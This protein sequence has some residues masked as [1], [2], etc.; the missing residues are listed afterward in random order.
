MLSVL[1]SLPRP[2]RVTA[3]VAAT[4]AAIGLTTVA[5]VTAATTPLASLPDTVPSAVA[6]ADRTGALPDPQ[7]LSIAIELELRDEDQP[8]AFDSG[9]STPGSPTY[10]QYLSAAQFASRFSPSQAVVDTVRTVLTVAGLSVG[11]VSGNRQVIDAS[12]RVAVLDALFHTSLSTYQVGTKEFFA[13]DLPITLPAPLAGIVQ[14]VI[15]LD[16]LDV[17]TP[18]SPSPQAGPLGGLSPT[19]I[20]TTY[21]RRGRHGADAALRQGAGPGGSHGLTVGRAGPVASPADR[22]V[23]RPHLAAR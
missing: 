1:W 9:V 18:A 16:D 20:N 4:S 8:A 21:V 14:G 3:I 2:V 7:P 17:A 6:H 12:G 13:N 5:T 15:G 19:Q 23:A 11:D 22:R 10:G